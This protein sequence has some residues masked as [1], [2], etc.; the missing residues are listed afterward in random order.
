[1][2][3]KNKKDVDIEQE[4]DIGLK[5]DSTQ[6]SKSEVKAEEKVEITLEEKLQ[7][8]VDETKNQLLR[9]AAEY[10]NFRKRSQKEKE[11]TFTNAKAMVITELLPV[12]DN[13]DRAKEN[14][15]VGSEDYKKGIDMTFKQIEDVFEKLKVESFGEPKDKFDPNIHSA[16]MHVEDENFGENEITDVFQKGYKLGEKV[17]RP[18][19]VKVAN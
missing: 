1:M 17:L 11:S 2:T 15:D 18:A 16:V 19:M 5:K 10:E 13:I 9:V 14:S 4:K 12:L 8:E 6:T 7:N 3:Q